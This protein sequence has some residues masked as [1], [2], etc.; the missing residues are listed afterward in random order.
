MTIFTHSPF[1]SPIYSLKVLLI[2]SEQGAQLD[3][4]SLAVHYMYSIHSEIDTAVL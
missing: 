1:E 4:W 3:D 2:I